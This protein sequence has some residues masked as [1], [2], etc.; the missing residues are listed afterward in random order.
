M[1]ECISLLHLNT[2]VYTKVHTI[3][4]QQQNGCKVEFYQ[5]GREKARKCTRCDQRS[6]NRL[7]CKNVLHKLID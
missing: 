5:H 4:N 2:K 6:H 7:T 3:M 1:N